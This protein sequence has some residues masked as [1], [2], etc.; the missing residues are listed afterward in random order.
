MKTG[1]R[2]FSQSCQTEKNCIYLCVK[3]SVLNIILIIAVIILMPAGIHLTQEFRFYNIESNDL[4]LYDW[5]DIRAKLMK[6]GGLATLLA[7]FLA[8]FMR[9]PFAGTVIVTAIYLAAAVLLN[10]VLSA[11]CNGKF[12]SGLAFLPAAFLYLCMENDYYRFQGHAAFLLMLSV[13]YAYVS[14][15]DKRFRYP[16]GVL[17]IPV[18]YHAAGSVTV[19]FAVSAMIWELIRS[20]L[21]GAAAVAYPAMCALISWIHVRSSLV[22]GWEYAVTPFMYYDWPST[23]FFPLYAWASVP[24]LIFVTWLAARIGDRISYQGVIAAIGIVV[25]FYVAGNLYSK[26]HSNS[27]Y[28]LIQEQYWTE[29]EDWDKI[30]KTAD[31]RQPTYFISYMNLALAQKGILLQ[32]YKY[33]NPQDLSSV[34]FPTPNLKTG[35]SLQSHVYSCWDYYA[36]ARQAAFDANTVTSG[37]C[38]PRQLRILAETNIALGAYDVAEKY[39]SR[40]EK[41]M[42]YRSVAEDLRVLLRSNDLEASLPVADEHVRYD[43]L[44]G[45]MRD[46]L[47]VNPSNHLL[48]QFYQLYLVLEKEGSK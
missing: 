39:I 43:G 7:S 20:G 12:M 33:Y 27:Y 23:Y 4:F 14:I 48:S 44:K 22:S 37:S 42:F 10:K 8:Q 11:V 32:N 9:I 30:I 31:L 35:L 28:R 1:L 34:M 21:K 5:D 47:D 6:T 2:L 19:V 13:L 46:I 16:A 45:D 17:L 15:S 41:T 40:L 18:L 38:N 25:S 3:K 26:V 29:N 36:A 24:V